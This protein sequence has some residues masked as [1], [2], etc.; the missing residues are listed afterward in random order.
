[1]YNHCS[2]RLRSRI[3]TSTDFLTYK[4]RKDEKIEAVSTLEH[5]RPVRHRRFCIEATGKT[6][7]RR[8][9]IVRLRKG[10]RIAHAIV[11]HSIVTLSSLSSWD[12][13]AV[14]RNNAT[15]MLSRKIDISGV[16]DGD[17]GQYPKIWGYSRI[18][19]LYKKMDV[20]HEREKGKEIRER[21]VGARKKKKILSTGEETTRWPEASS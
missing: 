13:L 17:I 10:L 15:S 20:S 18:R 8:S 21:E 2:L 3:V 11:M 9:N 14:T 19:Y 4:K 5:R 16:N 6:T 7:L 1:M 12:S